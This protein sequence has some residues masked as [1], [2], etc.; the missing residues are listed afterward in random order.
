MRDFE[1]QKTHCTLQ[2]TQKKRDR[3]C[4]KRKKNAIVFAR[5]IMVKIGRRSAH[6][7]GKLSCAC[8]ISKLAKKLPSSYSSECFHTQI[9]RH[10]ETINIFAMPLSAKC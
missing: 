7:P 2:K 10:S 9:I 8:I 5:T 3:N 6:L 1:D 4:K